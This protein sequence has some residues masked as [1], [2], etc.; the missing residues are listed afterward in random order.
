MDYPKLTD[1]RRAIPRELFMPSN[2]KA[3]MFLAKVVMALLV[4]TAASYFTYHKQWWWLYPLNWALT[5]TALFG[6]FEVAHNCG[7][8]A[9]FSSRRANR[10]MGH[11]ATLPLIYPFTQWKLWHDAHHRRPNTTKQTLFDQFR[12]DM[13]LGLDTAFSPMDMEQTRRARRSKF[14]WLGYHLSRAFT[15]FA[16]FLAPMLLSLFFAKTLRPTDRRACTQSLLFSLVAVP[17]CMTALI[18]HFDSW[19]ALL[20]FWLM[21]LMGYACWLGYYALLQHTGESIPVFRED[22]WGSHAQFVAVVNTRTPRVISWLHGGGEFHAVH[23]I[24]PTL[25]NY[26]LRAAY[27]ALRHSEYS[28][29]IQDVPFSLK[30]FF[31]TQRDCQLWDHETGTY[32]TI[33]SIDS[34][35][36]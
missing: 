28:E 33:R 18:W 31:K 17:L 19:F 29:W 22:N 6:L 10:I 4:C 30:R 32:R 14:A 27:D 13:T 24:A 15:P 16:V 11:L 1:V 36:S 34:N 8:H 9:Y 26:N 25:P 21:P 3:T 5:G 20:H 12:G 23:H 35:P 2:A 7:H